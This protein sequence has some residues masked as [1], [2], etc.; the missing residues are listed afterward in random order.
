MDG[1]VNGWMDDAKNNTDSHEQGLEQ[2]LDA[3]LI[4]VFIVFFGLSLLSEK[5]QTFVVFFLS[6]C[7]GEKE[8]LHQKPCRHEDSPVLFC[9][10]YFY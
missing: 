5:K 2:E 10:F 3:C 4:T 6:S 9:H 7:T 1:L 8:G